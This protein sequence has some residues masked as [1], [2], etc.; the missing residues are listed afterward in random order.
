M[1]SLP[2]A[3]A[4]TLSAVRFLVANQQARPEPAVDHDEH[5]DGPRYH[6]I[7]RVEPDALRLAPGND[8][9]IP[10]EQSDAIKNQL[11]KFRVSDGFLAP[12]EA[13][14]LD[15]SDAYPSAAPGVSYITVSVTVQA[16]AAKRKT[17]K[18]HGS[19]MR[20]A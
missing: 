19:G 18:R 8:V 2:A 12:K 11:D 1:L 16:Q 13:K 20:V 5:A 15:V 14:A 9:L 3:G 10:K 6:A 17:G 7:R 4:S